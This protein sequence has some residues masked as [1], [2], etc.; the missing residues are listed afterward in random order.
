MHQHPNAPG[1]TAGDVHFGGP[2]EGDAIPSKLSCRPGR[3]LAGDVG[4]RDNN[5]ACDTGGGDL[6]DRQ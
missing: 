6:V 4:G 1:Q 3:I 2:Q 5:D